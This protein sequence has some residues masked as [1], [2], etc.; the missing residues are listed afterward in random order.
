[1]LYCNSCGQC[2]FL[3]DDNF[4][5][6]R[7]T[8]GWE[9]CSINNENGETLDYLDS[10]TTDSEHCS[11]ECPY[12][13]S[14]DVETDWSGDNEDAVHKRNTYV[15]DLAVARANSERH[16]KEQELIRKAKD[17]NREWDVMENV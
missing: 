3:G 16:M 12:C 7:N 2:S 4:Y 9:R 8:S 10:E 15:A 1:M 17:P 14:E 13:S 11:Y 5:E 6:I